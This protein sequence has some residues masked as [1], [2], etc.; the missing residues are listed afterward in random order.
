MAFDAADEYRPEPPPAP[1]IPAWKDGS[2]RIGIHTSIA[3]SLAGALDIAHGLGANAVQIFSASPRMWG[4]GVR[5]QETDAAR[6][7][8]RR[9]ELGLGPVVI[10]AN[11]LVNLASPNPVLRARSM[12]AFHHEIVRAMALG[13][14]YLVLHPGSRQD[15]SAESAIVSI[16]QGLQQAARGLKLG[17]LRILLENTAGQGSSV[18][19]RFEELKSIADACTALPLGVCLDT[20]HL[21]AAGWDLR[22]PGGLDSALSHMEA[23][24]GLSRIA[25]VHVNDSKVPLGARVDRHEHVGKG[26]IGLEAF[27]RILNHPSL[28]GRAWILETPIDKPGDDLRNV[29]TLWKLVGNPSATAGRSR[30]SSGRKK[31]TPRGGRGKRKA[32]AKKNR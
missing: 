23:T 7:R 8:S 16:A 9:A 19:S 27:R 10:H 20:A 22:T 18:G 12:Q 15:A 14:D 1:E 4:G 13:A 24:I 30:V 5:I 17:E 32:A 11:Y 21:F 29:T 2:R 31:E 28:A 3:G 6:F 26:K 25:V